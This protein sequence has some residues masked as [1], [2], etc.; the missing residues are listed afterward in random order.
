MD[1]GSNMEWKP[2]D[3]K[4]DLS[5]STIG[6]VPFNPQLSTQEMRCIAPYTEVLD[7]TKSVQPRSGLYLQRSTTIKVP[8][9]PAVPHSNKVVANVANKGVTKKRKRKPRL[10]KER[11]TRTLT[12]K[13]KAHAKAVRDF[14]GG[15]CDICKQKKTKARD[16]LV[17]NLVSTSL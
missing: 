7:I 14:P 9:D 13:G 11:K 15:A 1:V 2:H 5:R 6:D 16:P 12:D 10:V 3:A 8:D 17:T 4:D